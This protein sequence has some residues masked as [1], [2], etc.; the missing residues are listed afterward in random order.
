M[1]NTA[2]RVDKTAMVDI[3]GMVQITVMVKIATLALAVPTV[4]TASA[5]RENR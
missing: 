3:T 5:G 2:V 1:A 4:G